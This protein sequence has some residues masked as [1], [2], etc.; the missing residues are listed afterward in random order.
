MNE[1]FSIKPIQ[2]KF[3]HLMKPIYLILFILFFSWHKSSYSGTLTIQNFLANSNAYGTG[4]T[5]SSV[6]IVLSDSIGTCTTSTLA[7]AG[8]LSITLG[9]THSSSVCQN[10]AS[11]AITPLA[12]ALG[13]ANYDNTAASPAHAT[14]GTITYT[15]PTTTYTNYAVTILG[16][17]PAGLSGS[18][19]STASRSAS[20]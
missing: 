12:N 4:M 8:V 20:C 2:K 5:A 10:I 1:F 11:V 9:G 19:S 7:Y 3:L 13:L 17:A 14:A 18:P 15:A 6:R 16:N